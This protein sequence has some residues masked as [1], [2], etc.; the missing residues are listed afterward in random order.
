MPLTMS[1]KTVANLSLLKMTKL[2]DYIAIKGVP[3][4]KQD[5]ASWNDK[6][7]LAFFYI[8]NYFTV[9][10]AKG[11]QMVKVNAQNLKA[12][13]DEVFEQNDPYKAEL[14][15]RIDQLTKDVSSTARKFYGKLAAMMR[16][17]GAYVKENPSTIS[18]EV[19]QAI[20]DN[21]RLNWMLRNFKEVDTNLGTVVVPDTTDNTGFLPQ[22][23]T[24]ASPMVK[25]LESM[26][27]ISDLY[28][29][30]AKSIKKKDLN[31][32]SAND[33]INALSK[34][35]FVMKDIKGIK[36]NAGVYTQININKADKK[37]IE[38]ALL[39]FT[40]TK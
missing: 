14:L 22:K 27:Y 3:L 17:V 18:D 20:K 9:K 31:K 16:V 6:H 7:F 24:H 25:L 10:D 19:F 36:P 32:M 33:K 23:T 8:V 35:S 30:I 26:T 39:N 34:L 1:V 28:L 11:G 2:T 5:I 15:Y 38:E 21:D 12:L 37:D 40:K 4:R 29:Q 13:E